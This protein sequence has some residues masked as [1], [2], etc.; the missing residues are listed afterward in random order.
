MKKGLIFG[1]LVVLIVL[2]QEILVLPW[3]HY[4]N[5]SFVPFVQPA[6]QAIVPCSLS[7]NMC[8][9]FILCFTRVQHLCSWRKQRNSRL[10]ISRRCKPAFAERDKKQKMKDRS[11]RNLDK[12]VLKLCSYVPPL[13]FLDTGRD[14]LRRNSNAW[15]QSQSTQSINGCFLAYIPS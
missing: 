7:H 4:F 13:G 12:L 10:S 1:W 14:I 5:P 15:A 11:P 2:I 9:R 8:L 6:W 3:L